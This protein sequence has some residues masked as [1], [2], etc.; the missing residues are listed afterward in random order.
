MAFRTLHIAA[1]QGGDREHQSFTG[2]LLLD[3]VEVRV[4][5]SLIE[6]QLTTPDYYPLTLNALVNAC[7]QKSNRDPVVAYDD[8]TVLRALDSLREKKLSRVI[9]G[10]DHRVP[11]YNQV[12]TDALALNESETAV[13]CVLMLRGA[14]TVGEIRERAQRMHDFADIADAEET[15]NRLM[16]RSTGALVTR[17]PRQAG[18]K[19]AR[20]AHLLSGTPEN[21]PQSS[22]P[23]PDRVAV[24]ESEVERLRAEVDQ[25][26]MQFAE[27]R[28]QFE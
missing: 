25:L 16:E 7:S 28:K 11:K 21:I 27:F 22:A 10:G 6:K 13:L 18:M 19:E 4:I 14:Q 5:G 2:E 17:L 9:T 26:R 1:T 12:F 23:A 20:Y 8:E 3:S 15:L 24:L